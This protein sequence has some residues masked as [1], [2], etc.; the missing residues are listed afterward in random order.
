M[1]S[2]RREKILAVIAAVTISGSLLWDSIGSLLM[3]PFGDVTARIAATQQQIQLRQ[4]VA[5]ET[6]QALKNLRSVNDRSLPA[7][8]GKASALYQAWLIQR[9]TECG[10]PSPS[11]TPSPAIVDEQLG[12]RLPFSVE[13]S[14]PAANLTTFID[15]FFSAPILHR[16][17]GLQITNSTTGIEDN[18][19]MTVSIEVLA[20]SNATNVEALP[21]PLAAETSEL[22]LT[23]TLQENDVFRQNIMPQ[24]M[25]PPIMD[26]P[27]VDSAMTSA[28]AQPVEQAAALAT[29]QAEEVA[30]E[31]AIPEVPPLTPEQALQFSGSIG[32]GTSRK[33]WFLDLRNGETY[34]L[35]SNQML[36]FS[37]FSIRILSVGQDAVVVEY[38]KEKHTIPLGK[39]LVDPPKPPQPE[40]SA[41][42]ESTAPAEAAPAQESVTSSRTSNKTPI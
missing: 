2:T 3:Q 20:L 39:S 41:T 38:K 13:C 19:Q 6:D 22:S 32:S 5:D 29:A 11:V 25:D 10:I 17:T 31:P 23:A 24:V 18:H 1:L 8:P 34:R 4:A 35:T 33:A 36:K 27:I 37:N 14:G 9:L 16:I 40:D 21:D 42:G 7:E 26:P 30:V 12:Y 28:S 15:R